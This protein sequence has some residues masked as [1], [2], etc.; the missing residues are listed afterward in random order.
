MNTRIVKSIAKRHHYVPQMILRNFVDERGMLYCFRKEHQQSFEASPEDVYVKKWL[1]T[2]R[3]AGADADAKERELGT[4]IEGPAH[5]IVD[6]IVTR[7]RE[8]R[9]PALTPEE[10]SKWDLFF[11]VQMR[12]TLAARTDLDERQLVRDA[13]EMFERRVGS[14]SSTERAVIDGTAEKRREAVDNAWTGILTDPQGDV[15]RAL[16]RKGLL[17]LV[18]ENPRKSFVVGSVPVLPMIP[19]GATLD[20]DDAAALFPVARDVAVACVDCC[21][22]EELRV[23]P[24]GTQG[25]ED[26]RQINLSILKQSSIIASGSK[27]LVDSLGHSRRWTNNVAR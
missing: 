5:P 27:K 6:K 24:K 23:L 21:G 1:Y 8:G 16:R 25:T 3:G 26:L 19:A 17:V 4:R 13:I 10:K 15:F 11:C 22:D 7:A 14:L 18:L 9:L 20:D 12:R 2:Q